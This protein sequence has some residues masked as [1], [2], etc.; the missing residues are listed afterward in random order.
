MGWGWHSWEG[1]KW[2]HGES[3]AR[4]A[5]GSPLP[6]GPPSPLS[7]LSCLHLPP[8]FLASAGP[9]SILPSGHALAL[10]PSRFGNFFVPS[11]ETA[12]VACAF[13]NE[14]SFLECVPFSS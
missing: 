14:N 12:M 9:A 4:K 8:F 2:G 11:L 6:Q 5:R 7:F 10:V 3:G 1:E 13:L